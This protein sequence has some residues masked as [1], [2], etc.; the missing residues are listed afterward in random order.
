[1]PVIV[2]T[3]CTMS[4]AL[5]TRDRRNS[6][7]ERTWNQRVSTASGRSAATST[8]PDT[9]SSHTRAAAV[10]TMYSTPRTSWLMPSSRSSR[11]ESR[12]LVW[13]EMMRPDVYD[14][15]NSSDSFCVWRNTRVRRSMS[16]AWLMRAA[17]RM[18]PE[19]RNA[20]ASP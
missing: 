5:A 6:C 10:N 19:M 3:K 18:Y 7:W 1:M 16:T 15:W 17:R 9:Q 4:F 12:S 14:S 11:I 20:P 8:S 2:S 13:R